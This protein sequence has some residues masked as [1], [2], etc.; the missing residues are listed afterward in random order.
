VHPIF[1]KKGKSYSIGAT[2]STTSNSCSLLSITTFSPLCRHRSRNSK[3]F[4]LLA[5]SLAF[6]SSNRALHAEEQRVSPKQ[7]TP[8][9]SPYQNYVNTAKAFEGKTITR[10]DIR[11]RDIFDDPEIGSIYRVANSFKIAT[12]ERIVRREMLVKPGD[13]YSEFKVRESERF[14][15][16]QRFLTDVSIKAIPDGEGV[17]LVVIV[18]DTWTFVPRISISPSGSGQNSSIGLTDTNLLGIGKRL[19]ILNRE[20]DG[21]QSIE[22]VYEDLRVLASDIKTTLAYFDREDG[23]RK[24]FYLGRPFRTFFDESSWSVDGEDSNIVGRLFNDGETDYAYRRETTTGRARYTISTGTPSTTIRRFY[25]GATNQ[26]ESFSQATAEDLTNL[27]LDPDTVSTDPSRLPLDRKFVGPSFGYQSV[28]PSFVSMNYIDRFERV[29]DYNVGPDTTLDFLFAPSA[30][31]STDTTLHL[32][33]NKAAGIAYDPLSFLRWE[34]GVA[35]RMGRNELANSLVRGEARYYSVLGSVF[36]GDRFLGRHTLAIGATADYGFELDGDRQFLLGSESGLRGY[37]RRGF[38]GT[39]RVLLN[40][41]DRVHLADDIFR[42]MS[43]GAVAF[44]DLGGASNDTLGNIFTDHLY[45]DLGI[46]LRFGFPRSS[47]GGIVGLDLAVPLRSGP[48]AEGTDAFI[49]RITFTVGQSF[50]ARLRSETL[51]PDKANLEVG[52][53]R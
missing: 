28:K 40:V 39:R 15:R 44:C 8:A 18:H 47:G 7:S 22:T 37:K 11:V 33:A 52:I 19:E 30:L 32:L 27:D 51:G 43:V 35:T 5:A 16:Q 48:A 14:I 12:K 25:V 38:D 6:I 17:R 13:I 49:P 53:D 36:A 21:R 9:T 29:E 4:A 1:R 20:N 34:F 10:I 23:E 26:E 3:I 42:I 46:G 41:E 31:G 2:V 24:I 45:G 50:S